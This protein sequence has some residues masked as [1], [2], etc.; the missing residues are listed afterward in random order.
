MTLAM[1]NIFFLNFSISSIQCGLFEEK[2]EEEEEEEE[3]AKGDSKGSFSLIANVIIKRQFYVTFV[4]I[5]FLP[6]LLH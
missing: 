4:P 2:E 3:R 1:S 6:S 5:T